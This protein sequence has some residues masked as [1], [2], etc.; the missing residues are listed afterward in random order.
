MRTRPF[1]RTYDGYG[2]MTD[3]P[4]GGPVTTD[5]YAEAQ[6]EMHARKT[7]TYLLPRLERTG[8]RA[9]LDVG[10]GLGK[11]ADRLRELGYDSYGVDLVDLVRFW[12]A[13]DLPRDRFFVVDAEAFELPFEDRSLDFVYT[14]GVIEHVGCVDGHSRRAPDYHEIRR[15]WVHELFRTVKVGG[16]LLL[17]GPNRGFPIDVAHGLD[18]RTNWLERRLSALVG[19]SVHRTVGD[20]FLWSYADMRRYL[21]GLPYR[22]EPQS[23]GGL[24]EYSRVPAAVRPAVKAYTERLP[25]PLLGTGFNPWMIAL[26]ERTG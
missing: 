14:F 8:A 24:V 18:A 22:L 5:D 9:V 11:M 15:R 7:E 16:H 3:R 17:G 26:V 13:L 12:K 10:C 21:D 20:Y 25:R 2:S 1:R 6:L 4:Y 19:A 23:V